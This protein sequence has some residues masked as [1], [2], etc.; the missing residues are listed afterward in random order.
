M[1]FLVTLVMLVLAS[2]QGRF[3]CQLHF[4]SYS[5]EQERFE[6]LGPFCH[7]KL[8]CQQASTVSVMLVLHS[9]TYFHSAVP[10]L[11]KGLAALTIIRGKMHWLVCISLN[12]VQ[13]RCPCKII[14]QGTCFSPV[15]KMSK[16]LHKKKPHKT[17]KD[18][19]DYVI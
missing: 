6:D 7:F 5:F 4:I 2:Q 10:A 8:R 9:Q 18:D 11:E 3:V 1:A 14:G 19:V 16:S 17:V 12:V 13:R 15:I